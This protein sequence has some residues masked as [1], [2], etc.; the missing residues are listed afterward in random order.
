VTSALQEAAN[1]N[2]STFVSK[3]ETVNSGFQNLTAADAINVV[4]FF[5]S[6][7][8]VCDLFDLAGVC[9]TLSAKNYFDPFFTLFVGLLLTHLVH[10]QHFQRANCES[11]CYAGR[12]PDHFTHRNQ[13]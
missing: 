12:Q 4:V 2:P 11:V 10:A 3:L 8:Q 1:G 9:F 5:N 7:Q 6:T 13:V